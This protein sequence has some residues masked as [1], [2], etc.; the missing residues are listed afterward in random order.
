MSVGPN[1]RAL[2]GVASGNPAAINQAAS[3]WYTVASGLQ[4]IADQLSGNVPGVIQTSWRGEAA[5][6]AEQKFGTFAQDVAAR[7]DHMK[8]V[9][10]A[11]YDAAGAVEK[12]QAQQRQLGPFPNPPYIRGGT[13][14]VEAQRAIQLY[15]GSLQRREARAG[16]AY[17][18]MVQSLSSAHNQMYSAVRI[19]A[20]GPVERDTAVRSG[21]YGGGSGASGGYSLPGASGGGAGGVSGGYAGAVPAASWEPYA[22]GAH[23][24]TAGGGE[25]TPGAGGGVVSP[26]WGGGGSGGAVPDYDGQYGSGPHLTPDSAYDSPAG[27]GSYTP[28]AGSGAGVGSG[29]GAGTG[30]GSGQW[31]GVGAGLGAVGGTAGLVGG[32]LRGA[33]PGGAGFGVVPAGAAGGT[34]GR[35]ASGIGGGRG[36]GAGSVGGAG[37]R[38]GAGSGS[39]RG[40]GVL[41]AGGAG[42]ST[43]GSGRGAAARDGMTGRPGGVLGVAPAGAAGS[44]GAGGRGAAARGGAGGRGPT[45]APGAGAG[46]RGTGGRTG[47]VGV[48]AGSGARRDSKGREEKVDAFAVEDDWFGEDEAGPAVLR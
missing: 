45:G 27:G 35:G 30:G 18:E 11:L 3:T 7:A 10:R 38:P 16:A 21:G 14:E 1:E 25:Y 46:G 31:G 47:G 43:T 9:S 8:Q 24:P 44:G 6:L 40:M 4:S 29:A 22:Q 34:G 19:A 28:G 26:G 17:N 48:A 39:A 12:A 2:A 33:R 41:A 20:D 5:D 23:G 36:V 37:G 13:D 15:E 32:A 42:G